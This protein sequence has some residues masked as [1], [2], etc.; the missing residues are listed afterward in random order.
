MNRVFKKIQDV[1]TSNTAKFLDAGVQPPETIDIYL[2]QPSAPGAFEFFNPAVFFDY[3]IDYDQGLCYIY[4]HCLQ[5][6][7]ADTE[8]FAAH[9]DDGLK[10]IEYLKVIKQCLNKVRPGKPFGALKLYQDIPVQ[11]EYYLYHQ[12]TLRCSVDTGL[13]DA[14]IYIDVPDVTYTFKDGRLRDHI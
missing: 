2:G 1:L 14:D 6:F 5:D 10:Y 8:N 3:N 9:Q 7:G 13:D 12:I 11:S 4:L